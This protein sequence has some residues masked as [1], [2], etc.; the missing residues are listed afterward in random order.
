[1]LAF[2]A[3]EGVQEVQP[4]AAKTTLAGVPPTKTK[5]RIEERT[6]PALGQLVLTERRLHSLLAAEIAIAD[7]RYLS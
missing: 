3:S 2:P 6:Q 1:M 7:T 5:S 4:R